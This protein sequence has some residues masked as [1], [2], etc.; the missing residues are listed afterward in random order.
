LE[1]LKIRMQ[2]D[3]QRR[4]L[5]TLEV[6]QRVWGERGVRGLYKGFSCT[7]LRDFP[8][9]GV[10]FG[11]YE[12]LKDVFI[13]R[14]QWDGPL[15]ASLSQF[16]AGGCAGAAAWTA[17]YPIDVVKS[18]IQSSRK[19]LSIWKGFREG[20]R[21]GG[22]RSFFTGF[23]TTIT[24]GFVCSGVTFAAVEGILLLFKRD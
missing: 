8:S 21:E 11:V 5:G 22:L 4:P 12:Y 19:P 9:Y 15:A 23:G 20:Y 16:A 6:A 7:M 24:R 10:W 3:Q 13:R 2:M 18:R 17:V 14:W 1:L